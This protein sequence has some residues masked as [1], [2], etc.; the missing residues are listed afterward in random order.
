M[1]SRKRLAGSKSARPAVPKK[2]LFFVHSHITFQVAVAIVREKRLASK[3]IIFLAGR[4]FDPQDANYPVLPFPFPD[5]YF[6]VYKNLFRGWRYL[7]EFD[8]FISNLCKE[9]FIYYCPHTYSIFH[10]ILASHNLYRGYCLIEEGL[11]SYNSIDEM[12]VMT[13]PVRLSSK[14]KLLSQLIY[15]GRFSDRIFFKRDCL[16]TYA[17]SHRA[18]P[19][20]PLTVTLAINEKERAGYL[21]IA[22][23]VEHLVVLDST[24]ETRSV[25]A[26]NF[27]SGFSCV[28]SHFSDE[29]FYGKRLHVKLHPYQYVNRWF[30]DQVIE[31]LRCQLPK[32]TVIE[33]PSEV[34]IETLAMSSRVVLYVG[35]T[36]LAIYASRQGRKVYSFA[37]RIG[38]LEPSYLLKLD[39]QPK[40]FSEAVE[41]L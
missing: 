31:Y 37:R 12:N 24:V 13:P 3:D 35:I 36:S 14:Q 41:F 34:S 30:A 39:Q 18:F 8:A 5:D 40:I 21:S 7:R 16:D 20:F 9:E 28:V 23:E 27:I 15:A 25:S 32:C 4:G 22:E 2:H 38:E 26:E 1:S 11:S 10:P 19:D 17:T 29:R 33:I 6:L